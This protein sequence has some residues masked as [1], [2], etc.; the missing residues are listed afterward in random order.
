M[1]VEQGNHKTLRFIC[2][3]DEKRYYGSPIII[4]HSNI[5][6]KTAA[7]IWAKPIIIL[8]SGHLRPM[9]A[10]ENSSESVTVIKKKKFAL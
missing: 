3:L 6:S 7:T 9:A 8:Y 10:N 5:A 1:A 2:S 4:R